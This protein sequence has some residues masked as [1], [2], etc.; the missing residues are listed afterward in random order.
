MVNPRWIAVLAIACAFPVAGEDHRP[1]R[2]LRA[3]WVALAAASSLDIATSVGRYELNP[4][5]GRGTFGGR[6]A[7]IKIG[8]NLG[9]ILAERKLVRERGQL[10]RGFAVANFAGAAATAGIAA[11]NA[12]Q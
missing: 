1:S 8:L 3:S 10:D 9:T 11:R 2:L 6:Q 4:A 12:R 7:G 5:L